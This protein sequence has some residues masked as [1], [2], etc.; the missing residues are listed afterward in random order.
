MSETTFSKSLKFHLGEIVF[1]GLTV[2]AAKEERTVDSLVVDT[3]NN[4][5]KFS[6]MPH[7][8]DC[9][10]LSKYL[11][12]SVKEASKRCRAGEIPGAFMVSQRIG[13]RV[14]YEMAH[15]YKQS[16]RSY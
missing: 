1:D 12:I 7:D 13:W 16:L 8:L 4:L 14:P 5:S 2:V 3:L 11:S 6:R 15:A 10:T 9:K